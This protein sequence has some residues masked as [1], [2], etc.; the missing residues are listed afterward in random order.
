MPANSVNEQSQFILNLVDKLQPR[1]V[2]HIGGEDIDLTE[3][4]CE[5]V[6]L[7]EDAL[8]TLIP[9]Y[10][11]SEKPAPGL[12]KYCAKIN[13]DYPIEMVNIP[14]DKVLPDF[15]FQQQRI[16]LALLQPATNF[17]QAMVAFYYLD[18]MLAA[19]GAV[20]IS[21][22]DLPVM[23]RLCRHMIWEHGYR[24]TA[25]EAGAKEK[26]PLF[27]Q[28]V[29]FGLTKVPKAVKSKLNDWLHPDLLD[30]DSRLQ[31][32]GGIVYLLKPVDAG[33]NK[34]DVDYEAQMNMDFDALL[35]TLMK[36]QS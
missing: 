3:T 26:S 32:A 17:E 31:I 25:N 2:I 30:M 6:N 10:A 13:T 4:L 18:K 35:E 11:A 20:I 33:K 34:S 15:Y 21:R 23:K 24:L 12:L 1:N 5:G 8:L 19:N 29:K 27:T 14:A 28:A 7:I 9:S 36:E 16:D 22:A